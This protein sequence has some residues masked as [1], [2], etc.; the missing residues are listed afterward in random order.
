MKD[1][2]TAKVIEI[3]NACIDNAPINMDVMDNDL[4][5]IGVDSLVFIKIIVALEEEFECEIPDEKLLI[6]EMNTVNKIIGILQDLYT[7]SIG[8]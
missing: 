5:A 7:K 3:F 2:T 8:Q 6:S 1:I 4:S